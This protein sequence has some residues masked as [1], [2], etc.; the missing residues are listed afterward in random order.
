ML[1][2]LK[3]HDR[4]S[5]STF[6]DRLY[7]LRRSKG[8]S[9]EE[10]AHVIGV[11][12]QAVQKWESGTSRPDMDNL[13]SLADLFGVSLDY[14]LRG[15]EPAPAPEE[16][17]RTTVVNHYYDCCGGWHYEYRSSRT[18]HGL[19]LVHVNLGRR[20]CWARGVFAVGNIATGLVAVGGISV[21]LLSIG[22]LSL[23]LAALG[24]L[25]I[26][27]LAAGGVAVGLLALGA[28]AVGGLA[29]G[30][31][32]NGIWAA[33]AVASG[34]QIA[35]GKVAAAPLAIG[36]EVR[37]AVTFSA[38]NLSLPA[39]E[40]AIRQVLPRELGFLAPWLTSL[41]AHVRLP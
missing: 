9:Q 6:Q 14:L 1:K 41:A 11:S 38:G 22:A 15:Q 29:L 8:L 30:G 33:G 37:G 17:V 10:L 26:G 25:S 16:A 28:V 20:N 32:A 40:A 35:I 19:P 5:S 34:T 12:R 2:P 21:G 4:R 24:A 13:I 31:V 18:F 39:V 23:G 3:I 27:L 36:E 7:Q